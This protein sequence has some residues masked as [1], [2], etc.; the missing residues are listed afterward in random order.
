MPTVIDSLIV[1]VGLDPKKYTEGR[2]QVSQDQKTV[3]EDAVRTGKELEAR[4]AQAAQFFGKIR[5][6]A[7][8]LF[9][10]L[11]AGKGLATFT[12]DI[13]KSDAATG[14]L[15]KSLGVATADLGAWQRVAQ[16]TGGT[17][18]GI[19]GSL[20]GL[21]D[22][23]EQIK[24]TGT[25]ASAPYLQALGLKREDLE[26]SSEA[27]LKISDAMAK[28][29]PRRARAF[30]QALGFDQETI[31]LLQRGRPAVEAMLRAEKARGG[32]SDESAAA[33]EKMN[34]QLADLKNNFDQAGREILVDFLPQA[35]EF[36]QWVNRVLDKSP[37]MAKA[38][39]GI[40]AAVSALSAIKLSTGLLSL[41]GLGGRAAAGAAAGG[42]A[43]AAAGGGGGVVATVAK[44][45][46]GT[47]ARVNPIVA[48][49]G[50]A[51]TPTQA[52]AGEDEKVRA[53]NARW[54]A[55]KAAERA[56]AGGDAA[57]VTRSMIQRHEGFA[58]KAYWDVNAWRVGHGSDTITDPRT[59]KVRAVTKDTAGV[60][61]EMAGADLERRLRDEFVPKAKRAAGAAWDQY[62]AVTQGAITSVAYNYGSVPKRIQAAVQSGDPAKVAEA[63]RSL[64]G[65]NKT[66][67][68]P[69]GMNYD[70]RNREA[71][72]IL[73]SLR[74]TGAARAAKET[75]TGA[76]AATPATGSTGPV[77]N[78]VT[79]GRIEVNT[80]A[81]DAAGIA[82]DIG[83]AIQK[84]SSNLA[85]QANSGAQ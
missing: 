49:L 36:L 69:K 14:R 75:R 20:A 77:S 48:G 47:V 3:R 72:E 68:A 50:M 12:A 30:G 31:S 56:A 76:R 40:T 28:M 63:I 8:A 25:S 81:T 51:L 39:W 59:G 67:K 7:V 5:G 79:I 82:R 32:V 60:T 61:K 45:V 37:A 24:L 52:N 70:R 9:T 53:M 85:T 19:T 27:L 13:L 18:E 78:T 11:T 29:D 35:T 17:A 42:A 66:A 23:F 6:Q 64:Q 38:I 84:N 41:L 80:K 21:V 34:R 26:D 15:S 1:E 22:Q 58:T 2:K 10:T 73:A 4:G 44:T 46:L 33:T 83:P 54:E 65:D 71:D 74:P 55:K 16:R 62:N 43:T 57:S